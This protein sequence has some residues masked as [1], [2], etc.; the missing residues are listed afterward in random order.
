MVL[1]SA[2]P[3]GE[4]TALKLRCNIRWQGERFSGVSRNRLQLHVE[5]IALRHVKRR[6]T[7][8]I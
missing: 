4:R 6:R 5:R 3:E 8:P 2:A 1:P 7:E